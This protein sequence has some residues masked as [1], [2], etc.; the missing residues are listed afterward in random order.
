MANR[1]NILLVSGGGQSEHGISLISAKFF[2]NVLSQIEGVRV[3]S[4][5]LDK[6][7][8]WT[9]KNGHQGELLPQGIL[10]I[11]Q[12]EVLIH[13]A[14]SSIHGHPGESGHIHNMFELMGIPFLGAP[15]EANSL[16]FNKISTKI[17][18]SAI[19]IPHTPYRFCSDCST[20]PQMQ[21]FL[22]E[23]KKLIVKPSHQGSSIGISLVERAE[24]LEKALTKALSLSPFA[25]VEKALE[26]RELEV[27]VFFYKDKV[28]TSRPGEIYCPTGF[29]SYE[30]KYDHSSHTKTHVLADLPQDTQNNIQEY[31]VKAF[32]KIGLRDLAR[33]DFFLLKDGQIYLNEINTMPGHTPISMFPTMMENHGISYKHF[34]EDRIYKCYRREK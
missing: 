29:Y 7:H 13:Y 8:Q 12:T 28:R 1:I 9:D 6:G 5:V 17:W 22:K 16:C 30:E 2:E 24:D 25:L 18:L 3:Y 11:G 33:I 4:L 26:A 20:L 15:G 21:E 32:S 19:K 14:I 34:L 10:R 27:S 31:A 23:H